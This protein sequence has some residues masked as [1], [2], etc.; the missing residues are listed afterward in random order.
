MHV[1]FTKN[2]AHGNESVPL[3]GLSPRTA[4]S[5]IRRQNIVTLNLDIAQYPVM[6]AAIHLAVGDPT[7]LPES[8]RFRPWQIWC[9]S[10]PWHRLML[11]YRRGSEAVARPGTN[12]ER[13][14]IAKE[15]FGIEN[16]AQ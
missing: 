13:E 16:A 11:A 9:T 10:L 15:G 2:A 3:I 12:E 1:R 7:H 5:S 6:R 14:Q 4:I 8:A